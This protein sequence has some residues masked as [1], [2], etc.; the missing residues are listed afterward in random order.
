MIKQIK[1]S[2]LKSYYLYFTLIISAMFAISGCAQEKVLN[3]AAGNVPYSVSR[4]ILESRLEK[5]VLTA[6]LKLSG[7]SKKKL[8]TV[9]I[10]G[11]Y[12]NKTVRKTESGGYFIPSF[13]VGV[14][15][16]KVKNYTVGH[17]NKHLNGLNPPKTV[18][19]NKTV[20][21]LNGKVVLKI[22]S[23]KIERI[24]CIIRFSLM[25]TYSSA[26]K[27]KPELFEK[28]EASGNYAGVSFKSDINKDAVPAGKKGDSYFVL[29]VRKELDGE[30]IFL[31]NG[32]SKNL[33]NFKFGTA[34]LCRRRINGTISFIKLYS[35]L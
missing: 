9:L 11:K 20:K 6:S 32:K 1:I 8:K 25:N 28:L 17:A 18:Y 35:A 31:N 21:S 19:L 13:M 23:V 24:F 4:K 33:S 30:I 15:N 5:K 12:F 22:I 27:Y 7:F 2:K 14:K 10:S 29:P 34:V 16:I 3:G 26:I